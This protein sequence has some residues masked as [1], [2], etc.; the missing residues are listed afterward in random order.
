MTSLTISL[1][2]YNVADDGRWKDTFLHRYEV[3]LPLVIQFFFGGLTSAFVIYFSR[4]VSLS[5][6]MSFFCILIVLLFANEFLKK[7]I[8]NKYLQFGL[9]FFVSF[10]FF[11]FIVPVMV[12]EVN[13]QV[14]VISGLI[15]LL[16][17]LSFIIFIYRISPST[18]GEIGLGK[19]VALVLGIYATINV[20]YYFKLIPPVPLALQNGIIASNVEVIDNTYHVTY[21]SDDWYILWRDHKLKFPYKRGASVYA[22]TSVFAP[23]QIEQEIYHRWQWYNNELDDWELVDTIGYKIIGGRDDGFRGY[24]YKKNILP[25]LWEVVVSTKEGMVLGIIEFE[26]VNE[27]INDFVIKEF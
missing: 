25:G 26:V 27:S 6:T 5:R 17:T 1:Y 16:F 23:T 19:M 22:F 3:Y 14:Y 7:R 11:T 8:S 2:L 10:T 4:S 13:P 21:R 18:R 12:K 9:Y 15:S 24:T 20:F